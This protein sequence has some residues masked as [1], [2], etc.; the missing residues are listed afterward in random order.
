ME[1]E[2]TTEMIRSPQQRKEEP[3][4]R[5]PRSPQRLAVFRIVVQS[6]GHFHSSV[7]WFHF[8]Q[9]HMLNRARSYGES[10][11]AN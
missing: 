4:G 1:L 8:M 2:G 11:E 6:R 10:C 7:K 5:F 9:L 3:Y